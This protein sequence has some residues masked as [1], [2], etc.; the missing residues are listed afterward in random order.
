M[1]WNEKANKALVLALA[2][3]Q[4]YLAVIDDVVAGHLK[5]TVIEAKHGSHDLIISALAHVTRVVHGIGS[6]DVSPISA[7][8]WR[9]PQR[10]G[11]FYKVAP[12]FAAAWWLARN[13]MA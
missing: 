10:D 13:G 1:D 2:R 3:N 8:G 6:G 7:G 9:D 12:Q 5:A 11:G 4:K